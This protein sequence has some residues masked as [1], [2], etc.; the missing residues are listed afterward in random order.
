[1]GSDPNAG[2]NPT[3]TDCALAYRV[4]DTI[5]NVYPKTPAPLART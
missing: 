5:R 3:G 1:M 2:Y 4:A